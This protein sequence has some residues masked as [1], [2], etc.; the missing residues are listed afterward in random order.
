MQ[1]ANRFVLYNDYLYAYT[2]AYIEDNQD[3]KNTSKMFLKLNKKVITNNVLS[4]KGFLSQS[5][6]KE[7]V[8]MHIFILRI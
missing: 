4:L 8:A 7:K 1:L 5:E 3:K 6:H 2:Y